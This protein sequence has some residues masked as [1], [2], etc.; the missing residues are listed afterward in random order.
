MPT[1]PAEPISYGCHCDGKIVN[2][3]RSLG[4]TECEDIL[5]E[6]GVIEVSCDYCGRKYRFDEAAVN[7]LFKNG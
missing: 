2:I 5:L 1:F 6:Q 3:V 7:A 4:K